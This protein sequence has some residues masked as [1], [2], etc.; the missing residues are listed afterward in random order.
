MFV[1][2]FFSFSFLVVQIFRSVNLKNYEFNGINILKKSF[3]F[4]EDINIFFQYLNV[5]K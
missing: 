4:I 3:H 5:T 2:V 1:I